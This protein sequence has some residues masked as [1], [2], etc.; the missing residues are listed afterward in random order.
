MEEVLN[1]PAVFIVAIIVALAFDFVNGFHDAANAIATVVATRVLSP[2][3]AVL[4]AAVCNLLGPL[5]L[6]VAV[7]KAIGSGVVTHDVVV[8]GGVL[9]VL[10]ALIGAI[11]WDLLTWW[12]G[13]PTSSS[14]ALIGGLVGAALAVQFSTSSVVWYTHGPA[15]IY[16]A[17]K[18]V[19]VTMAFMF[20]APLLGL[21]GAYILAIANEAAFRRVEAPR[22]NWWYRKL[23]L[24]SAAFYSFTHGANDAQK[25][26]GVITILLV[27]AAAASPNPDITAGQLGLTSMKECAP[28]MWVIISCATAIGLGT[29]AG[30]WRIVRTMARR[31]TNLHPFEGF[32]AETGSAIVLAGTA[33]F[34]IP[35]STT[36][37]ISGSI[38]GVGA[39]KNLR[40]V[41]WGMARRIF[42]AWIFTFPASAVVAFG[43]YWVLRLIF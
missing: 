43:A 9:L 10:A 35:V 40:S 36:H 15:G 5:V 7:A 21:M 32:C 42:W 41:R 13:I 29:A 4:M 25:V 17:P 37:V 12:W 18:G 34:G 22:A 24:V 26:M 2:G 8:A 27:A 1:L 23:Q 39:T 31:I 16:D 3:V 33:H 28:P 38:M 6:G 20:I 19:L 14:H 30:G 11:G